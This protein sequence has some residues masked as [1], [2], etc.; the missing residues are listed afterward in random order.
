MYTGKQNFV[1]RPAASLQHQIVRISNENVLIP[2]LFVA[3]NARFFLILIHHSLFNVPL[4]L[5]GSKC[6]SGDMV[7]LGVP[8]HS[9]IA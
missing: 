7:T 9:D 1:P 5:H 3:L 2:V 8:N 4:Q 6:A